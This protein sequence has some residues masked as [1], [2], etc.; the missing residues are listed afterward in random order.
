MNFDHGV[1]ARWTSRMNKKNEA[2]DLLL[3]LIMEIQDQHQEDATCIQQPMAF[4]EG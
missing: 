3:F 4:E 1:G 2:T